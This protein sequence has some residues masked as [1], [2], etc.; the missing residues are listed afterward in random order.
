MELCERVR[1]VLD[2]W[3]RFKHGPR[4]LWVEADDLEVSAEVLAADELSCSL[5]KLQVARHG[6]A[7]W[8][9]AELK[10]RAERVAKRV[11]YLLE[12]V[13]PIE[14]DRE[15]G[16]ALLRSV[17]P[18]KRDAQTLYYELLL[19]AAGRLALVRYRVT[20]GEPGRVQVPCNLT[21][22]T[23][24]KLVRDLAEVAA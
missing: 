11:T 8:G 16:I 23:L 20:S 5:E 10:A 3:G 19:S 6:D 13:G 18:E 9:E 1:Q 17:P 2:G 21:R 14:L 4:S 7:A 24:E 12:H 22:E 15:R